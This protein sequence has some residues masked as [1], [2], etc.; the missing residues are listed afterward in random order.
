MGSSQSSPLVS[1]IKAALGWDEKLFA[2]PSK[3]AYQLEDVRP[4]NLTIP[5][6]PVAVTYPKTSAQVAAIVKVAADAGLKV[7]PRSGGHSY[8]NYCI[9]G[10]D[11]AVVIDLRHLQHFQMDRTT[12]KAKVGGGTLLGDLTKRMHNAGNRAM[13]HGTCPQVGIGGHATIG[14]LGPSSRLWGTAL[15]HVEEVEVVLAD[16]RIVRASATENPDIFWAVK[17]AGASFGIVTEFVVRTEPEP[18]ECVNYSYSFTVGSYAT[19]AATFKTW[20][21]F[22]SDPDLTRKFASEVIISELG[23]IISG[24]F[25]GSQ[26]EFNK[27]EMNKKFPGYKDHHTLIFKDWLG[28]AA[29]W[30]ETV[31]LRLAG[32]LAAPLVSKSLTFNGADL[33]PDKA[34]D[35]LFAYLDRVDKGTLVWFIIFDLAGG[36]VNDVAQDATSYA[37]RDALFYLQSYAVGIGK[38]KSKT[39]NF[40]TGV[41]TTIRDG[42]PGG[43]DFGAYPGYVDPTLV[44]G[45]LSYWRTNL[46]RLQQIKSQVDPRDVFHNPQS[47]PLAGTP[48]PTSAPTMAIARVRV[49]KV[50]AKLCF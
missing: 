3:F 38:V 32:G 5:V 8:A 41:N 34:V 24:T 19:L 10:V 42:M 44:N 15:D 2:F 9:G 35:K 17:G 47:V 4:Y 6:K 46:P 49:R 50:L 11:G 16:S 20:Q 31:A 23:M 26:A 12:W 22:V 1:G 7:Q 18:G 39:K 28:L 21:K 30:G 29:H 27:L 13:A 25:F 43:Q 14:G 40:L 37:H 36:A 48:A 33:I 45:P